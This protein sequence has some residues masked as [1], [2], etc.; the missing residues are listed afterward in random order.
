MPLTS[1]VMR[2][3]IFLSTSGGKG[4]QSAVIK[5]S[6]CTARSTMTWGTS[7]SQSTIPNSTLRRDGT[8]LLVRAPVTLHSNGL[9][10]KQGSKGLADLVV[11][12][13]NPDL[14]DE[15]RVGVLSDLDLRGGDLSEDSDGKTRSREGVASDEVGG[16][17][18]QSSECSYF[19]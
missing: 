2:D 11:Q 12:S 15:D 18:E 7:R 17:V 6:V 19:I 14:L 9:D 1:F 5:S 16:D 4:N 8:R 3:E 10:G 13:S